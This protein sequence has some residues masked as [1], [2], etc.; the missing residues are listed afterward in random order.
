MVD[1][2]IFKKGDY[3]RSKYPYTGECFYRIEKTDANLNFILNPMYGKYHFTTN[4]SNYTTTR[5]KF[6]SMNQNYNNVSHF[7]IVTCFF[8]GLYNK[9]L[10]RI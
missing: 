5:I 4:D 1:I 9:I 7:E 10:G 3:V 8:I 2:K 6:Y